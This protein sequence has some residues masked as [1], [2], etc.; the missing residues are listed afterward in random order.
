MLWRRYLEHGV[1][2]SV[3][4]NKNSAPA[5]AQ[6]FLEFRL[7]YGRYQLDYA[8][9]EFL[10]L[11]STVASIVI[12]NLLLRRKFLWYGI[13][14]AEYYLSSAPELSAAEYGYRRRYEQQKP[15][16][17]PMCELFPTEVACRIEVCILPYVC[18]RCCYI[19]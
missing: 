4:V 9:C 16:H 13:D 14:V 3:L 12:T 1:L 8:L 2:K 11:G 7:R 15:L 18:N 6:A 17:D 19:T 5:I 10:N